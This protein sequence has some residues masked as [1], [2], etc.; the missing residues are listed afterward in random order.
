VQGNDAFLEPLAKSIQ[1]EI[2]AAVKVLTNPNE[3]LMPASVY[4][5]DLAGSFNAFHS[6][7]AG[8][9]TSIIVFGDVT[10]EGTWTLANWPSAEFLIEDIGAVA[11]E[12]DKKLVGQLRR[13]VPYTS[14][15]YHST[16]Y[17]S[18]VEPK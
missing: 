4:V 15:E 11:Q 9:P 7:H 6:G 1:S 17:L 14:F 2:G 8:R 3:T 5:A 13:L 12:L 16:D 10:G 18:R